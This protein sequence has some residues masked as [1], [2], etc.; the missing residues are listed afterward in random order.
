M[1]GMRR[2]VTLLALAA[3]AA[4]ACAGDD[5]STDPSAAGGSTT[6]ASAPTG[7]DGATPS[8]VPSNRTPP[9]DPRRTGG[10]AR[11]TS[12]PEAGTPTSIATADDGGRTGPVG[13]YARRLLRPQPATS[14]AIEV[15]AEEGQ[16]PRD[17]TLTYLEQVLEQ[18]A[19]KPVTITIRT[20]PEETDYWEQSDLISF[21]DA[22]G[23]LRATDTRP[24]LRFLALSGRFAPEGD[25]IG[26]AAR[27]DLLAVFIDAIEA[28]ATPLVTAEAMEE[29]VAVHELGHLLGLVDIAVDSDRDDPEHPHH[30]RNRASVMF[31]A[32]DTDLVAQVLQGPPPRSF[33][34]DD[35][36][37]LAALRGG[38]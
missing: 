34:A 5:P 23:E 4:G 36:R 27:G 35:R 11:V 7:D 14:I 9:T 20:V 28:S 15:I 18:A 30:S 37:D 13:A 10:T 8:P 2:L 33:D 24:V 26:V 19:A 22:R 25:A 21:A 38:A 29:A 17:D 3:L 1:G 12:P 6:V 32:I 16:T 31:W